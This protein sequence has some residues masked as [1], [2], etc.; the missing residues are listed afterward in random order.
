MRPRSR[1]RFSQLCRRK[2]PSEK[3][4]FRPD[5]ETS[6]RNACASLLQLP[7]PA[8]RDRSLGIIGFV[9][10]AEC[11]YLDSLKSGAFD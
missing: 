5:A 11:P 7:E 1:L 9:T 3:N 4:V 10:A 8:E 6:T 2:P